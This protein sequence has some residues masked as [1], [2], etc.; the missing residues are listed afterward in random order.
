[1]GY[2]ITFKDMPLENYAEI[3][4]GTDSIDYLDAAYLELV[5]ASGAEEVGFV[6]RDIERLCGRP[7]ET[8]NEYIEERSLMTPREIAFLKP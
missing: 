2:H 1:M 8:Y 3:A 5:K 7:A 6:T 4:S